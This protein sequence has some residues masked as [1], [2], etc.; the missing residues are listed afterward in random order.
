MNVLGGRL[1]MRRLIDLE[2]CKHFLVL[3][4]LIQVV[5]CNDQLRNVARMQS[6][7]NEALPLPKD[8]AISLG[9]SSL[10]VGEVISLK[11]LMT[12]FDD[13]EHDVSRES[14][15]TV[16]LS[17][18]AEIVISDDGIYLQ[19]LAPGELQLTAI[20]ADLIDS[21]SVSISQPDPPYLT[22]I[23]ASS[24][25]KGARAS[26]SL[27][28]IAT[29][30]Q[31]NEEDVTLKAEWSLSSAAFVE[32]IDLGYA[33]ELATK[34]VK[35]SGTVS[36]LASYKGSEA[37]RM[38]SYC[39][40]GGSGTAEDPRYVCLLEDLHDVRNHLDKRFE[41]MRDIDMTAFRDGEGWQPIGTLDAPFTGIFDGKLH[42]L[43]SMRINRPEVSYI[44]LF[45]AISE[46]SEVK[47]LKIV[48][49]EVIGH[50][51]VGIA[52]GQS[53]GAIKHLSTAGS[54]SGNLQVGGVV[55]YHLGENAV[56]ENSSSNATVNGTGGFS[57]GGLVGRVHMY[58]QV[59][60][61]FATGKVTSLGTATGG[62]A[63]DLRNGIIENSYASG[64]VVGVDRVGGFIGYTYPE[65]GHTN[66]TMLIEG[67]YATGDVTA[68][69]T[70]AGGFMGRNGHGTVRRSYATGNVI[71]THNVGGFAGESQWTPSLIEDSYSTGNVS[72]SGDRVGGFIGFNN[73][74]AILRRSFAAGNVTSAG[75]FVGGIVGR[76]ISSTT[77]DSFSIGTVL[78]GGSSVGG[79][80]GFNQ[81]NSS[82]LTNLAWLKPAASTQNCVGTNSSTIVV[83]CSA[84]SE[85][86]T[87]KIETNEPLASWDFQE[88]WMPQTSAL[89]KLRLSVP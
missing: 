44:G 12:A 55:G 17:S 33:L 86:N 9:S 3:V 43:T 62:L 69:G 32:I 75:D 23:L 30:I 31:G 89:P 15:W 24:D 79:A 64:D 22:I 39:I 14:H 65:T 37:T 27:K 2:F 16:D 1:T 52:V 56:I 25:L 73:S 58:A 8:F 87:L 63:G 48:D 70:M 50:G 41:L 51:R 13:S 83:T 10:T 67:C 49:A 20:Y 40:P 71:G 61:S 19:L 35:A 4:L 57:V 53:S 82:A 59:S 66:G 72:A 46:D 78:G 85:L 81:Y 28:L 18:L 42:R 36:L 29:D 5:S 38:V 21:Q 34:A 6:D 77:Q 74:S 11:A 68:T 80:I 47:N 84:E 45:G 54:I 7:G 60:R 76:N 88:V 26:A